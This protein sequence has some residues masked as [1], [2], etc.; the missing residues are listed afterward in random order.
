V[1][2]APSRETTGVH[3]LAQV[4]SD[5]RRIHGAHVC[6]TQRIIEDVNISLRS[7]AFYFGPRYCDPVTTLKSGNVTSYNFRPIRGYGAGTTISRR[8]Q[9]RLGRRLRIFRFTQAEIAHLRHRNLKITWPK[10]ERHVRSRCRTPV[11]TRLARP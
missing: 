9:T 4:S 2:P 3:Q 6:A 1:L 7:F 10:G 8:R 11:A 5:E